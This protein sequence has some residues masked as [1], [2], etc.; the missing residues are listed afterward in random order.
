L[1]YEVKYNSRYRRSSDGEII[2]NM[3]DGRLVKINIIVDLYKRLYQEKRPIK[4]IYYPYATW[5]E[6]IE[7]ID[8][9]YK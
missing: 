6:S 5:V 9:S 8:P 2:V 3:D 1:D 4:E 7:Y